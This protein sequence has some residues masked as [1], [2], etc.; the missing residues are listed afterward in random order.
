MK[1]AQV[2][3]LYAKLAPHEQA[4]LAFEA[5]ARQDENEM[6]TILDS[7]P[8][9]TY[10]GLHTDY[11][12]RAHGLQALAWLYGLEYWKNFSTVYLALFLLANRGGDLTLR[13]LCKSFDAKLMAME[14]ALAEVCG[15]LQINPES[16]K[17]MAWLEPQDRYDGMFGLPIDAELVRQYT[18]LFK[19]AATLI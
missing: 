10:T 16:V 3:K 14:I 15:L 2:N 1:A 6:D 7:V 17:R 9:Q 12:R 11:T 5:L 8:R 4:T 18:E 13:N 19:K